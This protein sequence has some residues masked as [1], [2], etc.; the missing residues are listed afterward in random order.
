MVD[1]TVSI[2]DSGSAKEFY[3]YGS[4][5]RGRDIIY[6]KFGLKASPIIQKEAIDSDQSWV[7][8]SL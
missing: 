3:A 7:K 2:F 5:G 1:R 8:L 6:G 4:L